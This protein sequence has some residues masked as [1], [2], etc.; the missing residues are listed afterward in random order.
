[1]TWDFCEGSYFG[2]SSAA[3]AT[4][5]KTISDVVSCLE[6]SGFGNIDQIDAPKNSYPVHP[7]VINADPPYYDNIAYADLSDFFYVWLRRSLSSVWPNLFRRLT[8]PK[9]EELVAT[10]YRHGGKEKA[11]AFFMQGMGEALSAMREAATEGEPL[12]IY[13]AF[14]QSEVGQD[15]I[16]SAGWLAER[17]LPHR[18]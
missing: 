7:C 15:G 18:P 11:E 3:L 9:G 16:T 6:A 8:T 4:I 5:I 2:D 13:Y 12:V 1:M 10:P 17:R 14:K